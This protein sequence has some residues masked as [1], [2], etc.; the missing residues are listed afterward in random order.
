MGKAK[1]G[2]GTK[3][4]AMADR[5]GLPVAI[6][7]ASASPHEV[8]LVQN[9]VEDWF[10]ADAPERL[11]GDKAYDSDKLDA[12]LEQ[13]GIDLI[14]PHRANRIPPSRRTVGPCAGTSA[15]GKSSD[16]SHGC[17]TFV[18]SCLA[19]SITQSISWA[20]HNSVVS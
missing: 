4:M 11:I 14:A 10:V 9:T 5:N 3:I 13:Q 15:A 8:T 7:V 6:H 19:M 18:V 12:T 1:R 20:S 17:S 2:K 16:C